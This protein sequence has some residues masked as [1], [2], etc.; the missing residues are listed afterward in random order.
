MPDPAGNVDSSKEADLEIKRLKQELRA[1]QEETGQLRGNLTKVM[2]K[3]DRLT[4]QLAEKLPSTVEKTALKDA[5]PASS[6]SIIDPTS[7]KPQAEKSE[8]H[9]AKWEPPYCPDCGGANES[10]KNQV[11]CANCGAPLGSEEYAKHTMKVCPLCGTASGWKPIG[12]YQPVH[13]G[14]TGPECKLIQVKA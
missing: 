4:A 6:T 1:K 8:T 9:V 14:C 11:K 13:T 5:Q 3:N 12:D 7:P 10:F 2:K